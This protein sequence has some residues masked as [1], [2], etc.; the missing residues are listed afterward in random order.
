MAKDYSRSF[1][2]IP[3]WLNANFRGE[4]L[5]AVNGEHLYDLEEVIAATLRESPLHD[6]RRLNFTR[7]MPFNLPK[8]MLSGKN[9]TSLLRLIKRLE[10]RIPSKLK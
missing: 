8:W 1:V 7:A 4:V 3:F 6:E 9:R 2:E 10:K 5:W